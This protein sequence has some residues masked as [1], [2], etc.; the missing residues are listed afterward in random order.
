MYIPNL[1][2]DGHDTGVGYANDW[3]K[4]ALGPIL[5]DSKVLSDTLFV[6]TFD[7]DDGLHFNRIYTVLLGAGVRSGA[8]SSQH[9]NHYDLLK[10]VE[11]IFYLNDLGRNDSS[12]EAILDVWR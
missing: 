2:N 3:L 8:R 12:A 6:I 7:E 10:T 11:E 9:Y 5:E 1:K 4:Q